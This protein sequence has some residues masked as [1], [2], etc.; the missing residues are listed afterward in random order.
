MSHKI[1]FMYMIA[2][3]K[4]IFSTVCDSCFSTSIERTIGKT[5]FRHMLLLSLTLTRAVF[6]VENV[7]IRFCQEYFPI[8]LNKQIGQLPKMVSLLAVLLHRVS[9]VTQY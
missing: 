8:F 3:P 7:E 6:K 5:L 1:I 9:S 4:Q 2:W